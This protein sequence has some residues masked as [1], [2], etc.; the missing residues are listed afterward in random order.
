MIPILLIAIALHFATLFGIKHWKKQKANE[1]T[2]LDLEKDQS[3]DD[4]KGLDEI[5]EIETVLPDTTIL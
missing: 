5:K 2:A 3:Q 1:A 4:I